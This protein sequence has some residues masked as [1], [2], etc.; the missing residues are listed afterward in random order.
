[1]S[2]ISLARFHLLETQM[3]IFINIYIYYPEIK[4]NV[5]F[6]LVLLISTLRDLLTKMND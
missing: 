1:M 5:P 2:I 6:P 4:P 3:T